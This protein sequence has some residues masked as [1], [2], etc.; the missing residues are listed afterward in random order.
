MNKISIRGS[1]IVPIC[2]PLLTAVYAD[3]L[4]STLTLNN[5]PVKKVEYQVRRFTE[6]STL[7][8]MVRQ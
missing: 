4:F 3:I 7:V 1:R 8:N 2:T 5:N 6:I